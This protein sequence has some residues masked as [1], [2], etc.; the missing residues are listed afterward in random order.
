M[1]EINGCLS[2]CFGDEFILYIYT[3]Y[4]MADREV[5]SIFRGDQTELNW[6]CLLE[7]EQNAIAVTVPILPVGRYP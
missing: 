6:V 3:M 5:E 7:C 4:K 1:T 2:S